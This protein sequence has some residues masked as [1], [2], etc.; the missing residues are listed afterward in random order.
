MSD[1]EE[2]QP[3]GSSALDQWDAYAERLR[4]QLPPAPE[5]LLTGYVRW[6]PWIA[7]IFGIIGLVGTLTLCRRLRPSVRT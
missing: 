4:A 5:G 7:M 2:P 3:T 6:A 1:V